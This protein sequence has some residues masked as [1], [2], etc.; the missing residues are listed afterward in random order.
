MKR[1]R[2]DLT[3]AP[4]YYVPD[5]QDPLVIDAPLTPIKE[6][7]YKVELG[8]GIYLTAENYQQKILIHIRH[9]IEDGYGYLKPTRMGVMFDLHTW[10]EFISKIFDFN[11]HYSSSS[12]IAHN[13]VICLNMN[14]HL[15]MFNLNVTR[16]Y[17][18]FL[19][20]DQINILKDSIQNFNEFLLDYIY[21]RHIPHLIRLHRIL[22]P[23]LSES[24]EFELGIKFS[25]LVEEYLDEIFKQ[26]FPC[27]GCAVEHCSQLRHEC[28]TIKDIEKLDILGNGVLL[29]LPFRTLAD[30]FIETSGY[31]S[32]KFVETL[33]VKYIRNMLFVK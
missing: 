17:K 33:D 24:E 10:Y 21:S 19:K 26:V 31:I 29:L 32:K 18:I 6:T 27:K 12:F 25:T 11:F 2:K 1:L 3:I 15:Q 4:T 16:P 9:F 23:A 28:C 5:A 20:Q 14:E 8:D 22:V 7:I 13:N 30:K